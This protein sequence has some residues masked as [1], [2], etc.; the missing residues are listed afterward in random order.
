MTQPSRRTTVLLLACI[1]CISALEALAIVNGLN[2]MVLSSTI[3][4]L[5]GLGGYILRV[6]TARGETKIKTGG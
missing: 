5:A 3:G 4:L 6:V 1:F 2:G